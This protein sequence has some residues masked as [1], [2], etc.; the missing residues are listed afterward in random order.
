MQGIS[1]HQTGARVEALN[2][3]RRG[4]Y[5]TRMGNEQETDTSDYAV[6]GRRAESLRT[7]HDSH[8]KGYWGY[9]S[10]LAFAV[11]AVGGLIWNRFAAEYRA[12]NELLARPAI[13]HRSRSRSY[14]VHLAGG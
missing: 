13:Q 11:L 6:T 3:H 12:D 10:I 2:L 5:P 9:L 4:T 1:P 7:F 8:H 14:G